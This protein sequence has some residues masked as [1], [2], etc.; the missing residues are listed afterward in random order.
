MASHPAGA[1][2]LYEQLEQRKILVRHFD[3]PRLK[4]F[5]RITVGTEKNHEVLIEAL[6]GILAELN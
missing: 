1:A 2:R 5:L 3:K 6:K 4:D